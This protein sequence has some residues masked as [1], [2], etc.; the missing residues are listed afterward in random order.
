MYRFVLLYVLALKA[1]PSSTQDQ[2][3]YLALTSRV[4]LLFKDIQWIAYLCPSFLFLSL[5][6]CLSVSLSWSTCLFVC[7]PVPVCLPV[8]LTHRQ[9]HT[10][11]RTHTSI[12]SADL[13][14]EVGSSKLTMEM[15]IWQTRFLFLGFCK[16]RC[17]L[18]KK[19]GEALEPVCFFWAP[20]EK[21]C[22]HTGRVHRSLQFLLKHL[23]L[24]LGAIAF[25]CM[26]LQ[27]SPLD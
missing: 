3:L 16:P 10:E 23:T 24:K 8:S 20:C 27:G 18:C 2:H 11:T 25:T 1:F 12:H 5:S 22:Q 13:Y 6:L 14:S 4:V 21:K 17:L 26:E 15:A 9:I 7:V 19:Q